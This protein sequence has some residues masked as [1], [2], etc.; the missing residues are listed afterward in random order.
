MTSAQKWTNTAQFSWQVASR[1]VTHQCRPFSF[2]FFPSPFFLTFSFLVF[3]FSLGSVV[4]N[5]LHFG[6][7]AFGKAFRLI[8]NCRWKERWVGIRPMADPDL[9]RGRGGRGKSS[10]PWDKKGGGDWE[11]PGQHYIGFLPFSLPS[12]WLNR[13]YSVIFSFILLPWNPPSFQ[14]EDSSEGSY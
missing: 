4:I 7:W 11:F 6:G 14:N 8:L 13:T 10:R 1:E 5:R 12:C 3:F 9:Q 2:A